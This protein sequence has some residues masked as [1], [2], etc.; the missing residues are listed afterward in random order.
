MKCV[1][2]QLG[3]FAQPIFSAEGNYPEI[4]ASVIDRNSMLEGRLRSRLPTFSNKWI[5]T[6]R[7]TYDF[8]GLNYYS[9]R[10][11]EM[12]QQPM[13]PNPS[14]YRDLDLNV[15]TDPN[16]KRFSTFYSVPQGCGD[17]L[18]YCQCVL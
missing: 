3:W 8:L 11:V 14:L 13:G 15:Q 10:Y 9:S 18:R 4:M 17:L 2:S 16:W 6:I 5:D 1:Y 7:G 12:N